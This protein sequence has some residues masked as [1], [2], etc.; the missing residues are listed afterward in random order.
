MRSAIRELVAAGKR[1]EL[2]IVLQ[3][4]A[5]WPWF[6]E[7]SLSRGLRDLGI[8][9]ADVLLLGWYN[10]DP[11]E[12]TLSRAEA[13]REKGMFRH[14]AIS[15]HTRPQF[16]HFA[17][18]RR[19]GAMHIRYNAVHTG[20]ER[21]VF[22]A[23][24][25]EGRP[26]IV[27]FTATCWGKLLSPSTMPKGEAPMRGRDA[28]RFVLTNPDFNVCMTGPKNAEQLDE[29]LGALDEGPLTDEEQA[30]IRRIGA[31]VSGKVPAPSH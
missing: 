15:G 20:A 29:A 16:V 17:E 18:D 10:G 7:R 28:Y 31:F 8:D 21:D 13:M 9:H 5:R 22:P 11:W 26:G 12:P 30:R 2:V 3:S 19:Y 24:P 1:D 14:L 6:M 27:A 23:M 4:Y 25:K